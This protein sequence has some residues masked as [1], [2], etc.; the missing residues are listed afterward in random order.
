MARIARH[1]LLALEI[2]GVDADHHLHHFAGGLL[3]FLVIF[4]ER[5][6]YMAVAAL[7]AQR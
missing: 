5:V 4:V 6:L 7:H 3:R 2:V 1:H